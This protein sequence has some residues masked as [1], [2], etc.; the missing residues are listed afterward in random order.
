MFA[1]LR[2]T[3]ATEQK[4]T[5]YKHKSNLMMFVHKFMWEEI[6]NVP[7]GYCVEVCPKWKSVKVCPFCMLL[8]EFFCLPAFL[9]L[10]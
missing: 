9:Y 8:L 7:T 6:Q 5:V 3:F 4:Q 2:K 10:R 1:K